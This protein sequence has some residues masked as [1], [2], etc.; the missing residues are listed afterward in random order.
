MTSETRG[1]VDTEIVY[2]SRDE[3]YLSEKPYTTSF[4]VNDIDGAER[5]NHKWEIHLTQ[6]R[7]ARNTLETNLDVHG[8]QYVAWDTALSR[9]DFSSKDSI[10]SR[11]YP[12]LLGLIRKHF[13][14][15]KKVAFFDNA[16]RS[17]D[18]RYPAAKGAKTAASQPFRF[19]HVDYTEDGARMKLEDSLGEGSR[20]RLDTTRCDVLNIWRL[21]NPGP[22]RDWPLAFCDYSTI[23]PA[24]D[25]IKNDIVYVRGLGENCFLQHSPHHKWWY[26]ANQEPH[27]VAIF[28]NTCV[29]D[30][31]APRGFHCAFSNPL[32]TDADPLRE[33]VE[34]R[35]AA[36]Y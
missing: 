11:Y 3:Q 21:M 10:V 29:N 14:R 5:D 30:P 4:P 22:T 12:E 36:F 9:E 24:N 7:D 34:V 25:I 15:Y 33:S 26:L 28:R 13:P 8:F 27:E 31:S 2:F 35:L 32:A 6:V 17:R 1:L 20:E 23:D 16:I 19:A 18:L